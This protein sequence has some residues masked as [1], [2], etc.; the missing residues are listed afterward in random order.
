MTNP[1]D[2]A[3]SFYVKLEAGDAPSAL[4]MMAPDMEWITMWHS[5]VD[6]RGPERVAEGLF[7]PLMAKW[8][9]FAIV[10]TEF[11]AEG[12]SVVSLGEFTS[13]HG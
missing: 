5:Q 3:R 13:A 4:G 11:I 8:S 7:E 9:S 6:G 10:P 2:I 1:I 12:D